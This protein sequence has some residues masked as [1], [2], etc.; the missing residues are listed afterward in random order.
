[1]LKKKTYFHSHVDLDS[2]DKSK[3]ILFVICSR[4][5]LLKTSIC[6]KYTL[7]VNLSLFNR[8][9]NSLFQFPLYS[10]DLPLKRQSGSL[11]ETLQSLLRS[12]KDF[13]IQPLEKAVF[14]SANYMFVTKIVNQYF[15]FNFP[16]HSVFSLPKGNMI[17]KLS[18]SRLSLPSKMQRPILTDSYNFSIFYCEQHFSLSLPYY[19]F[20][21]SFET[22]ICCQFLGFATRLTITTVFIFLLPK[23]IIKK[24]A[25]IH[26]LL[27]WIYY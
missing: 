8:R 24:C 4:P 17:S 3:I 2:L 9:G 22:E 16:K 7:S 12:G 21:F 6:L 19:F 10:L 23:M 27:H 13:E 18:S 20:L 5:C 11:I 15:Q 25:F 26:L 14:F 1:M